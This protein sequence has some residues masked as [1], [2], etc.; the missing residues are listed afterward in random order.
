L[1]ITTHGATETATVLDGVVDLWHAGMWPLAL[2]VLCASL[3]IPF[4]KIIGLMYLTLSIESTRHR[5]A[6]ARLYLFIAQVGRWSMLDVYVISLIVAVLRFGSLAE[7]HADVG[8]IAFVAVV[9]VTIMVARSFD[10]RLIWASGPD[11]RRGDEP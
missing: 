8:S 7:G 6:R 9:I 3:L 4:F 2:I 5:R 10:P 1:T 11:Q